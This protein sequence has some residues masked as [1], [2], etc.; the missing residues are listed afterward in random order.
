MASKIALA[1][2]REHPVTQE[3]AKAQRQAEEK[4]AAGLIETQASSQRHG[5]NASAETNQIRLVGERPR[6]A[7]PR[8][9]RF[10]GT[11]RPVQGLR[12]PSGSG[13]TIRSWITPPRNRSPAHRAP[14]TPRP[15]RHPRAGRI[16]RPARK[17]WSSWANG[18]CVWWPSSF[19]PRKHGSPRGPCFAGAGGLI[20]EDRQP[21]TV[22]RVH[23]R[24]EQH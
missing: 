13:G 3:G 19:S 8:P 1:T 20:Q 5:I 18:H 9:W 22:V 10:S 15:A 12:R 17:L 23:Q 6:H 11:L 2:R 16:L 21:V 4:A 24:E 7:R 14:G